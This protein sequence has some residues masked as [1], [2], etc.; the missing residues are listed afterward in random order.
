MNH[1]NQATRAKKKAGTTLIEV[2]LAA[3]IIA[4]LAVLASTALYYPTHLVVS[5]A[6]RQVALHKA[7]AEM[8][9][10]AYPRPYN[11]IINAPGRNIIALNKT[12][13]LDR[14]VIDNTTN[15]VITVT[16]T[17]GIGDLIVELITVRTP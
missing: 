11:E 15:K 2:I 1:L 6:R 3:I 9:E 8:E 4:M 5:D 10:L 14:L 17:N 12:M 16:V 7:N 13:G